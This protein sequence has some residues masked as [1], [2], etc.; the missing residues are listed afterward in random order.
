MVTAESWILSGKITNSRTLFQRYTE[1]TLR[2]LTFARQ[3]AWHRG[4]T[5]VTV[6]DLLAGLS[7]EEDTRAQRIGSLKSN[8]FYLRWLTA[9][10]ALPSL[11]ARTEPETVDAVPLL[12]AEAKRVLAFAVMEAD[13]DREYWIDADH[14]LRGLMRF[15]NKAHF[16]VLKT[17]LSLEAA[18]HASRLDREEHLPE[19]TP[20]LKVVQYL[21]R[22]HLAL[23]LPPALSLAC[24]LYILVQGLGIQILPGAK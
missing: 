2:A 23:W 16:A 5:V 17:E 4:E 15:P 10:P 9:L 13:R 14:L 7:V 12:D 6:S 3:E 18:R 21:V 11:Q 24:Y 1:S 22:K 19:E 8:A 20:N